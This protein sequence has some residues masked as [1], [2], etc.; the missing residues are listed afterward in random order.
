M[1]KFTYLVILL[2]TVFFIQT[3]TGDTPIPAAFAGLDFYQIQTA[4]PE[5]R[6]TIQETERTMDEHAL[7]NSVTSYKIIFRQNVKQYRASQT[8]RYWLYDLNIP[9]NV[10]SLIF[11]EG[12]FLLFFFFTSL[13]GQF[14]VK[15]NITHKSDGKKRPFALCAYLFTVRIFAKIN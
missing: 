8:L 15:L 2:T 3:G 12:I 13:P 4:G 9:S 1:N 14:C 10:Y 11:G 7:Q 6:H 5:N